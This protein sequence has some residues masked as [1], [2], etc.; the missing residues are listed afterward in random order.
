MCRNSTPETSNWHFALQKPREATLATD[1]QTEIRREWPRY[2]ERS[3]HLLRLVPDLWLPQELLGPGAELQLEGEPKHVVHG[4][5]EVQAAL[6]LLLDLRTKSPGEITPS[7]FTLH[8]G[9]QESSVDSRVFP[10]VARE[11]TGFD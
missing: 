8:S 9:G 1:P 5:Q 3:A 6:D 4:A 7:P 10:L 11:G 2:T